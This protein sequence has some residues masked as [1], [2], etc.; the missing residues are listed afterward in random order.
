NA[1]ASGGTLRKTSGCDGCD[2]A[3]GVAAQALTASAPNGYFAIST[4]NSKDFMAAGVVTG[5]P[6]LKMTAIPQPIRFNGGN[7][8]VYEGGAWNAGTTYAAGDVFQLA[9][10]S[11]QIAYQKNGTTFFTSPLAVPY[12]V[13]F[14]VSLGSAGSSVNNGM[15]L[16][17]GGSTTPIS[18]AAHPSSC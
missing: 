18:P 3:G 12:P 9:I 11:G 13:G 2:D 1:A 10:N 7:A 5:A 16:A 8:E 17:A 14:E 6:A 15:T 4:A